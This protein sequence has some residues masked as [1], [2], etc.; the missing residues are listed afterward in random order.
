[1]LRGHDPSDMLQRHVPSGETILLFSCNTNLA[2][3]L[4]SRHV[5]RSSTC[6][7][8]WDMLQGQNVLGMR[9]PFVCT[10]VE[11]VHATESAFQPITNNDQNSSRSCIALR[12]A[13]TVL[14]NR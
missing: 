1:M 14:K 13:T 10:A 2:T 3:I 8:L 9:C 6:L 11:R 5:A 4:S 12:P 7:T